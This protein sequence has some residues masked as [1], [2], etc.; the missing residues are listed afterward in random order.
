MSGN[1]DSQDRIDS[2]IQ[3]VLAVDPST[4]FKVR[5]RDRIRS[6]AL[7]RRAGVRPVMHGWGLAAAI[8]IVFMLTNLRWPGASD[9]KASFQLRPLPAQA[10][11]APIRSNNAR[12]DH[13]SP[14]VLP[15]VVQGVAT[16]LVIDDNPPEE[17]AVFDLS[18]KPLETPPLKEF[19]LE[20]SVQTA[21]LASDH[22]LPQFEIHTLS[23]LASNEGVDE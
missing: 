9:E 10:D 7:V 3:A 12:P 23:L 11:P 22:N 15:P 20:A 8:S 1:Q 17:A 4:E 21:A 16:V 6:E 2:L 18:V 14:E 13:A 5:L 19:S